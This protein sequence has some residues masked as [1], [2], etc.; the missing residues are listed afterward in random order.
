VTRPCAVA[1]AA[2]LAAGAPAAGATLCRVQGPDLP[3]RAWTGQQVV[4]TLRVLRRDDVRAASWLRPLAF[5]GVRAEWLPPRSGPAPPGEGPRI[6]L[7]WE[8]R[9]LFPERAGTLR[10]PGAR[11][12][13]TA[14]EDGGQEQIV[15]VPDARLEVEPL[16]VEGRPP[17]FAGVV[18][19]VE[20]RA[21]VHPERIALG[22]SARL[23][24]TL[25][26]SGNLWRAPSPLPHLQ[27]VEA[28]EVL[29]RPRTL[30]TRPG[31]RLAVR[32]RDAFDLVPRRSGRFALP[33]L[34]LAYFDPEAARYATARA[35]AVA[36]TVDP[37][38]AGPPASPAHPPSQPAPDAQDRRRPGAAWLALLTLLLA[39]LLGLAGLRHWRTR[40]A[41]RAR[42]RAIEDALA[43]A[44]RSDDASDA[45]RAQAR[46][47]RLALEPALPGSGSLAVEE[48][49]ARA[50][51][52]GPVAGAVALLTEIERARFAAEGAPLPVARVRDAVR[53]LRRSPRGAPDPATK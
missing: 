29:P 9:A 13:C 47:L 17:D 8:R 3:A 43:T 37:R 4:Y 52:R 18:G 31:D 7:V 51:A 5:P 42:H 15:D 2:A 28:L 32:V 35:A 24:V 38:A 25:S 14:P 19:P 30:E 39:T 36:L 41:H 34:T 53:G 6:R 23:V 10:I 45:L 1:V 21:R 27:D 50:P 22:E 26:G 46:A 48:L 49:A 44:E 40:G 20:M 11:L 12:R 33:A 16:P